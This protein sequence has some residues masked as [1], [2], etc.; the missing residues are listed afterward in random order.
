MVNAFP[1]KVSCFAIAAVALCCSA[2]WPS[3]AHGDEESGARSVYLFTSFEEPADAGLRLLW[4]HDGL[5]WERIPGAFLRPH[6]GGGKL[7]RDPSLVRGPD[8]WFHLVWTTAWRGDNGF[9]HARSRDLV[10]W[11]PQ[12]FVPVM[13][14]E[15]TTVNVWAPEVF[16]DEPGERFIIAWASTIP[17]RYPDGLEEHQNNHRMY[18][19]TTRDFREFTP[20]ELFCE[21]GFSVIDAVIVPL[22]DDYHLVLKDN[23]R[24]VLGLRV[25]Q[26]ESPLGPWT[27]VSEPITRKFTEGPTVAK[28]GD[29]Y[30]IYFDAYGDHKY[31]VLA[32]TDF[33]TF[34]DISDRASFPEGHKHGTICRVTQ[35]ELDYLKRVGGEMRLGAGQDFAPQL[36]QEEIDRRLAEVDKVAAQGPFQPNWASLKE[37]Q[38]PEWYADAKLGVFIHWGAYSVPAF[39]SEW[40]PRNMYTKGSP[41]YEHHLKTYGPLNKFG[42]K[43][44]IPRFKAE[45]FDPAAWAK[46]FKDAGVRYVVPVAEHHDGFPMYASDYTTWDASERGPRRDVI[47]DLADALRAQDIVVGASS[48]RAENWWFF[49]QGRLLDSDVQAPA[50]AKLYGPAHNKRVSESQ[51]EPPSQA[52]LDDWLLRSC[53]IVD[54][55]RPQVMY[56]DWWICQPVF[57]PYLQ[58]FAAYY[59]NR[60]AEW[61]QPA[62]INFKEWEGY[63][64]P[65]GTGVLDVERGKFAGIEPELWQT[66]TSVSKNSWG[67]I[68]GHKYKTSGQLVHDLIDIVSKNGVM[69][70]NIGP[71]ADGTIPDQEQAMLREIGAWLAV[72]GEAIYGTRPWIEFGEGPT[73]AGDGAFSDG[74]AARFTAADFR[75]TA[76]PGVVYAIGLAWPEDGR[77]V[78][79]SLA[80]AKVAGVGLLGS[81]KT[82]EWRLDASGLVVS[83]PAEPA[84]SPAYALRVQLAE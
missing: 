51:A 36:P 31:G 59:Y 47:A 20:T 84:A 2:G 6:A 23:T 62:A 65:R 63:S 42:Y 28:F 21:P 53:E 30:R 5:Q 76:K 74:D 22:G 71:K 35:Q 69:L 78:I 7:M 24:P 46:L 48:H 80:D 17:G 40:Y 73:T 37:F 79:E 38:S 54:K 57:Q 8:G 68:E 70:L 15:P 64:F 32:T 66:C 34:R 75:F 77:A 45:R 72:N 39:G 9:G 33:E 12:E 49:G 82:L 61:G 52:F 81:D 13:K 55:H 43:D 1:T 56:F 16:Y 58:R 4:S 11:S 18:A 25:A 60:A 44:F 19:T 27:D 14:H 10:H 26:G 67:Y 41:E 50:N 83:L 29:D 3:S